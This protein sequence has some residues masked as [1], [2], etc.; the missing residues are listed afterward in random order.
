MAA[1]SVIEQRYFLWGT[2]YD[3][4]K[5]RV[6]LITFHGA[7]I[8]QAHIRD[9]AGRGAGW[10]YLMV[11]HQLGASVSRRV[12]AQQG[13]GVGV[14]VVAVEV[15]LQGLAVAHRRVQVAAQRVDLP[16]LG[17]DAHLVTGA[18]AGAT[19]RGRHKERS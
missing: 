15:A 5:K 1:E 12:L 3:C 18:R 11:E 6:F 4:P 2:M 8:T 7:G 19:L 10:T 16:P 9:L 13:P 14:D 17:V